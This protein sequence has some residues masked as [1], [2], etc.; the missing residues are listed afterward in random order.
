MMSAM[1]PEAEV[2]VGGYR[3]LFIERTQIC[4]MVTSLLELAG[5]GRGMP[6]HPARQCV[7]LFQLVRARS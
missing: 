7:R 2:A 3:L 6:L 5:V 4:L 1:R